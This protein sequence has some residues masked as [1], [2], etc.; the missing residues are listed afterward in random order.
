MKK[1]LVFALLVLASC[2][3]KAGDDGNGS[4][5]PEGPVGPRGPVGPKGDTG[6]PGQV[7]TPLPSPIPSMVSK[8]IHCEYATAQQNIYY[9][10]LFS[11]SNVLSTITVVYLGNDGNTYS[12]QA[13]AW[14]YVVMTGSYTAKYESDT[15]AE[16]GIGEDGHKVDCK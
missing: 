5:G 13:Q 8:V 2:S 1:L 7:I 12:V 4:V 9:E 10:A 15:Q 11:G 3:G 14:D 16:I 6:A